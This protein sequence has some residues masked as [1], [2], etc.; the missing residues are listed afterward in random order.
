MTQNQRNII[1]EIAKHQLENPQDK[2]IKIRDL[3]AKCVEAMLATSQ[4]ALK[5]YLHEA[6]DHKI[7]QERV[8][9]QGCTFLYM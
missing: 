3:L 7:V 5:E 9:D 6:K 4:K 8:D 2:G 1:Q